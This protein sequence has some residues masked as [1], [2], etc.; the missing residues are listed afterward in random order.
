MNKIIVVP[1][2]QQ[3]P[4]LPHPAHEGAPI[5]LKA[6]IRNADCGSYTITWDV[7][8]S[9]AADIF[10]NDTSFTANRN[11]T[12][13]TV[14]DIG[15]LYT[16][17]YVDN[18]TQLNISVRARSDCNN[19]STFGTFKLFIY[20]FGE[21]GTGA[22]RLS[23]NPRDWSTDQLDVMVSMAIQESMWYTHRWMQGYSG[24]GANMEAR[25]NYTDA[26]G[27]AQ[28][29]FVINNHLPA[30]PPAA[31]GAGDASAE[32]RATNQARWDNDPYA[33]SAMRLLNYNVARTGQEGVPAEDEADECGYGGNR[34]I[35]CAPIAGTNDR[36]GLFAR[37]SNVYLTGMNTGAIS[38]VLPALS[39]TNV[40]TGIAAGMPWEWYVQQLVDYLGYQQ[41]DGGC[42]NGG[43]YYGAGGETDCRYSDLSTSQWA[44]IGMESAE[45][46]GGPYGV[47]VNNRHKFRIANNLLS[48][49]QG[50]GGGAYDNRR[51]GTSDLKLTGGQ[52]LAAR[53]LDVHNMSVD[54][55]TQPFPNESGYTH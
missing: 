13:S 27:I 7:D 49:Q 26:T 19:T 11:S 51:W 37:S 45:V 22:Q 30:Y 24:T 9:P 39:G 32:W 18:D 29:L 33:E 47:F 25:S 23:R 5:T 44:Y 16:V 34:V 42:A 41:R 6:I 53:W 17:P 3:N 40:R 28:W 8:Q 4:A 21:N 54:S 36:L 2:S 12:T 48:N 52:L 50:D 15:R 31:V 1:F 46:A 14:Y 35:P 43:W 55:T 10:A 38:T 20:N